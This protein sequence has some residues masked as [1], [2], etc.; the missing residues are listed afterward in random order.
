[1][2]YHI[3]DSSLTAARICI[4]FCMDVPWTPTKIVKIG[5]LP[6]F[7]HGILDNL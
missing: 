4:K 7:L 6:L 2:Y 5:M 1:M 3:F